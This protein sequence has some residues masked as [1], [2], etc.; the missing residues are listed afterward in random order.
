MIKYQKQIEKAVEVLKN[1]GVVVFPT[2]TVWGV[3]AAI[4]SR[5]GI[6][7]LYEIKKREV[8][9]PT[10]ILVLDV[11][12]ANKY[13]AMN[14]QAWNLAEKY[15]PGAL[16]LV[17][18]K[19]GNRVPME[20]CGKNKSVGLRAPRHRLIQDLIKELGGGVVATSANFA[21]EPAPKNRE[22][23]DDNFVELVD[24]VVGGEAGGDK[25]ST[26]VDL[27]EGEMKILRQGRVKVS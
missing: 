15:W 24:L 21:G 27:T 16:T 7:R 23:L 1:G 10:A 3:G 2:D 8:D 14:K 22:D 17:V 12:M 20:V 11:D 18:N 19:K 5:E 4:S 6:T 13:G 9:K 25:A 26:V